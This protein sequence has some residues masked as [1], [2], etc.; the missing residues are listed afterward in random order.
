MT[1]SPPGSGLV[2]TDIGI[3]SMLITPALVPIE[4]PLAGI[5][6]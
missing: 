4:Q 2:L 5:A 3:D 1:S 6:Q